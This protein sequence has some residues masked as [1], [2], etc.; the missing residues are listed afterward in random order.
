M[1]QEHSTRC[2]DSRLSRRYTRDTRRSKLVDRSPAAEGPERTLEDRSLLSYLLLP[3]PEDVVKW[4]IAPT[5]FAITAWSI[6]TW[7]NAAEFVV[8][9][10]ILEY[11]VYMARYQWNDIVGLDEDLGHAESESRRRLPAGSNARENRRNVIAS[12]VVI[13]VR[14]SAAL[15][16]GWAVGL[17]AEVGLLLLVVGAI[18]VVYESLRARQTPARAFEVRLTVIL[19]WVLVG[20]GYAVR[21][22]LGFIAAGIDPFGGTVLIGTVY[23]IAS[24]V[25]FILMNWILDATS[26]CRVDSDGTWYFVES[27]TRK[28]HLGAL[29]R[30]AG[31]TPAPV[32]AAPDAAALAGPVEDRDHST[33]YG[34]NKK[35]IAKRSGRPFEAPW[36][37]AMCVSATA[38]AFLGLELAA[39]VEREVGAYA[40]AAVVSLVGSG[41][42]V[43]LAVGVAQL[44][45]LVVAAVALISIGVVALAAHPVV[46][47]VPWLATAALYVQYRASSYRDLK[48]FPQPI[49]AGGVTALRA[50]WRC[51]T[52]RKA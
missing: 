49:I 14:V 33:A 51:V 44:V 27:L 43:L 2:T 36:N 38:G 20:L 3:R 19:I 46:V 6:G 32:A 28:P 45:A 34:G 29:L 31:I 25:M 16:V 47:V 21:A 8:L 10:L 30:F 52:G 42:L 40:V 37:V 17:L 15:L 9:W 18:A 50:A 4:V 26:Y 5:I 7:T 24:G 41:A 12:S 23:F 35:I 48:K 11:F 22:D 39:P 13:V 1:R